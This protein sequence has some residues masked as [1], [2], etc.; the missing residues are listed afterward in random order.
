MEE[1]VAGYRKM[2]S[3][4]ELERDKISG[5]LQGELLDIYRGMLDKEVEFL[6]KQ[7]RQVSQ[8]H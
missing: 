2:I 5:C 3:L 6:K 4:L 8:H 7:L 1:V